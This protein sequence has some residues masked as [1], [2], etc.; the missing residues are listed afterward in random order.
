[1]TEKTDIMDNASAWVQSVWQKAQSN[2][3]GR[4]GQDRT[5]R[6]DVIIPAVCN[7]LDDYFPK[8]N[9]RILELGCGD[10]V[11][12]ESND[13]RKLFNEDGF[14]HGIDLSETLLNS[15][16]E[17]HSASNI[18]FQ[19]GDIADPSLPDTVEERYKKAN[20]AL[21]VF[22]IQE[23]PN[24]D[25]YIHNLA[26]LTAP[27]ALTI[28]VSVHP[29]FADWLLREDRLQVEKRL[30]GDTEF[31]NYQWRWAGY[32]PI[33]EEIH[34]TFYLPHFQRT[35]EDYKMIMERHGFKL[36]QTIDLPEPTRDIPRLVQG[37]VSP[38]TPFADNQ[39]WPRIGEAPSAIIFVARKET[40]CAVNG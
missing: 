17:N 38:F 37:G 1:M 22:M 30:G 40:D 8:G 21:S 39:Y 13:F 2:W 6:V 36:E 20:V 16:R 11:L 19:Q 15:V 4:E 24:L 35:V 33:V 31:T 29:D 23:V 14:Y 7:L 9:V 27:G 25:V 12:L 34:G 32:Y 10:G 26:R 18:T 3:I 5:Y 28:T